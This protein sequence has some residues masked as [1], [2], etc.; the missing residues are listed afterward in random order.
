[1]WRLTGITKAGKNNCNR[2]WSICKAWLDCRSSTG[3]KNRSFWPFSLRLASLVV[4][5]NV[6]MRSRE[7]LNRMYWS[8]HSV[9][10]TLL[11]LAATCSADIEMCFMSWKHILCSFML[12]FVSCLSFSIWFPPFF[13]HCA[14]QWLSFL[15]S[16]LSSCLDLHVESVTLYLSWQALA[17]SCI[18]R[19]ISRL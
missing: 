8:I 4:G 13:C 18:D 5:A 2:G 15:H 9:I 19:F 7:S 17:L 12:L 16:A 1:M 6:R 3:F 14:L 11:L 10:D